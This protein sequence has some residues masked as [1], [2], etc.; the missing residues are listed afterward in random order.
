MSFG[1]NYKCI[2]GPDEQEMDSD[3]GCG[4]RRMHFGMISVSQISLH[5]YPDMCSYTNKCFTE[6][7][8]GFKDNS[9]TN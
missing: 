5:N 8:R 3:G 9:T 7:N 6:S 2:S 4:G 1:V